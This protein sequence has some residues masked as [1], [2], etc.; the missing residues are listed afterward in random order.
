MHSAVEENQMRLHRYPELERP[1]RE[2]LAF[3][4][5]VYLRAIIASQHQV[6]VM[7]IINKIDEDIVKN[8]PFF[9]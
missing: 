5:Q 8:Y 3:C 6:T 2:Y 1:V 9:Q 7:V 4:D